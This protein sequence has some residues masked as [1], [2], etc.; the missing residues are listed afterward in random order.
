M[1]RLRVGLTGGIGSGKT[2]VGSL[3]HLLGIPLYLADLRARVLMVEDARLKQAVV[4]LLG[5]AAYQ[6]NG[7]LD[8]TWVAGQV[9]G[10]AEKLAALNALVHPV[11]QEDARRWHESQVTP[12]TLQEAA[13]LYES[14]GFRHLDLMIVVEAPVEV[15]LARAMGRDQAPAAGILARMRQQWPTGEKT[16]RA[17]FVIHNSGRQLLVPQVLAVHRAILQRA[18]DI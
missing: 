16:K 4:E 17:D 15:R 7:E 9:F 11:V 13:L 6:P 1:K 3:F 12:Y 2:L 10:Q 18:A 5:A 8:R 14:G